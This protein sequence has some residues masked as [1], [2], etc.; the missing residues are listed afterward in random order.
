MKKYHRN[1]A[2]LALLLIITTPNQPTKWES[3]I[4]NLDWAWNMHIKSKYDL[5]QFCPWFV[6]ECWGF[7]L[8]SHF[9]G[10]IGL[11]LPMFWKPSILAP[12]YVVLWLPLTFRIRYIYPKIFTF[13]IVDIEA[14][15]KAWFT[16][17][18]V[19]TT[20]PILY[21]S[22]G[23]QWDLYYPWPNSHNA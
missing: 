2:K 9:R 8:F 12:Y 7:L 10:F 13:G 17:C 20:H 19:N 21:T 1:W 6:M 14:F 22:P 11:P 5:V 23:T 3:T 16:I 4:P 18:S 15:S